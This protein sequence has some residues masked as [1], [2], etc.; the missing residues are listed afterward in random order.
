RM[1][2][3][4][5]GVAA[6]AIIS[7]IPKPVTGRVELRKRISLTLQ[8]L[9]KMYGILASDIV[10][11]YD[12]H[13]EPTPKLKK[14]FRKMFLDIRRQIA[15]ERSHL[16]LSKFE[17]PLRGKF[18]VKTYAVLVEK[19]DNMADLLLGMGYAT[20]SIDRS[21][22]RNLVAAI[23]EGRAEYMASIIGLMKLLSASLSSKV[24]LPPFI[25]SPTDLRTK[26]LKRL[27]VEISSCPQQLDNATFSNYCSFS[28]C[29]G[30]F[31]EELS[32]VLDCV[33]RLVGVEDPEQWILLNA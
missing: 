2:L 28:L 15:D 1:L 14:A 20:R 12:N 4:I 30:K 21:W 17:P 26:F 11:N 25:A 23:R 7:M 24:T 10:A 18:P 9:S 33:K 3:V 32:E 29:A 16:Q 19:I 6:A 22:Q 31:S 13:A 5:I 8:D 27:S